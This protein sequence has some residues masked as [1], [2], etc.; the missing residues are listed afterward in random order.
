MC[1]WNTFETLICK[2]ELHI[3]CIVAFTLCGHKV[4]IP[5]TN[6]IYH[7]HTFEIFKC[8]TVM[9]YVG[10][11]S[12]IVFKCIYLRQTHTYILQKANQREPYFA[13]IY[14]RSCS[15][16]Y[17]WQGTCLWKF[18]LF[19]RWLKSL[20]VKLCRLRKRLMNGHVALAHCVE[21]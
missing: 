20:M 8:M 7:R 19:R 9:H 2:I 13:V 21:G 18:Y 14:C 4:D 15:Y 10:F 5:K 11:R 1:Q 3:K 16:Q 6:V 12:N 17:L